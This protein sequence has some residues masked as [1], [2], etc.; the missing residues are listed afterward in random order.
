MREGKV[1][2]S[3]SPLALSHGPLGRG[4]LEFADDAS[5][6]H[7]RPRRSRR[8]CA[9]SSRRGARARWTRV[10]LPAGRGHRS[11]R[12]PVSVYLMTTSTGGCVCVL[13][14]HRHQ[15]QVG[16]DRTD[17]DLAHAAAHVQ[18]NDRGRSTY[19]PL[20]HGIIVRNHVRK[21][22]PSR[23][24][25]QAPASPDRRMWRGSTPPNLGMWWPVAAETHPSTP[26]PR[27]PAS[28]PMA[29]TRPTRP[30]VVLEPGGDPRSAGRRG[31][32]G[33]AVDHRGKPIDKM[34]L[35]AGATV[36]HC[37]NPDTE[38]RR[39][40]ASRSVIVAVAR[41][42]HYHRQVVNRRSGG[43][44]RRAFQARHGLR[45]CARRR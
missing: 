23:N 1:P 28:L 16:G 10:A 31:V 37:H 14:I 21:R 9:P 33:R 4:A 36:T 11:R 43:D 27:N 45:A 34:M 44:R 13:C 15:H 26:P 39:H 19:D 38:T 12:I 30:A 18:R 24:A 32:G 42:R 6:N 2:I 20:V 3:Q 8:R 7:R 5:R 40:N 41:T 17:A 35:A 25:V 22:G 29:L